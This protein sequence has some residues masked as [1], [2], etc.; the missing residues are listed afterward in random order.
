MTV[1][2]DGLFPVEIS[3]VERDHDFLDADSI[4]SVIR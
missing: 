3:D 2:A 4:Q 1:C